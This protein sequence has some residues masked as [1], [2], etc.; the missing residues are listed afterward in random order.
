MYL[1]D[2]NIFLEILLQQEKSEECKKF[3]NKNSGELCISDFSLHSIGVIL[4]R[5][6]KS[7]VYT[8]FVN[9]IFTNIKLVSIPVKTYATMTKLSLEK[10]LDFDDT[11]QCLVAQEREYTLVTMDKDFERVNELIE[12]INI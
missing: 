5:L 6:K 12:I 4:F 9:D 10:G 3:I 1:L 2:T 11:Y 8:D 7:D